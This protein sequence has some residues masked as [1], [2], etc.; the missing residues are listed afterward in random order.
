MAALRSARV[1]IAF[2]LSAVVG[3][4]P[5]AVARCV[6]TVCHRLRWHVNNFFGKTFQNQTKPQANTHKKL[7]S[8]A[9]RRTIVSM[10]AWIPGQNASAYTIMPDPHDRTRVSPR[11]RTRTRPCPHIRAHMRPR[12]RAPPREREGGGSNHHTITGYPASCPSFFY[13]HEIGVRDRNVTERGNAE[14][15][16]IETVE[17]AHFD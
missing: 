4:P 9:A 8:H 2:V 3:L 17:G 1:L 5:V 6:A 13:A 11:E 7:F 10:S 14:I 16:S 15:P 12:E